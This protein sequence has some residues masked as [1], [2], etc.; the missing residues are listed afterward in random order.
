MYV[1]NRKKNNINN[2]AIISSKRTHNRNQIRF[3]SAK[4][5]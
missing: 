5:S 1:S 4:D 2:F 3:A